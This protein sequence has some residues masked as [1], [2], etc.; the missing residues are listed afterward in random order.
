MRSKTIVAVAIVGMLVATTAII[1]EMS[2]PAFALST[3]ASGTGSSTTGTAVGNADGGT[4]NPVTSAAGGAA[5]GKN[6]AGGDTAL[7]RF[8][9]AGGANVGFGGSCTGS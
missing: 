3:A 1:T 8:S 5:G 2:S 7:C 4:G 9:N 6:S